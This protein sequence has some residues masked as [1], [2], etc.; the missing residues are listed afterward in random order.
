VGNIFIMDR[1]TS[2]PVT[3]VAAPPTPVDTAVSTVN[4]SPSVLHAPRSNQTPR[5]RGYDLDAPSNPVASKAIDLPRCTSFRTN[6]HNGNFF[7]RRR[8]C[9]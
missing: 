5:K 7:Q 6:S 1:P 9:T 8:S 4:A 3:V 2:E